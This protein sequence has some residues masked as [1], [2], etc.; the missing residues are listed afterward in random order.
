MESIKLNDILQLGEEQIENAKIRFMVP[1]DSINFDPNSDA[2]DVNKQDKIN[3]CDLV[4]NR[5]S[6]ISFKAGVIAIGF[7]RIRDDY[8]LM[9]GVVRVLHDNGLSREATAEYLT[10]KYNYRLVI[11]F[12]KGFQNGI[13]LAKNIIDE[14]EVIEIWNP[15]KS[16]A[17]TAFPGYKNIKIG[18]K[19]LK[20]KLDASDEWRT[21]LKSRKGVYV[22]SDKETGK[23][24]VGSAYGDDG[25]LGRWRTYVT[26]GY[27]KHEV[28][29]GKY[30]NKKLE[31]LVSEKGMAYIEKNFQYA[32]LETFTDDVSDEY[33][34][35]RESY[36]K[37]VLLTRG[38]FGYNVN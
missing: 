33:I 23:L 24:Y 36:W 27:D 3:L 14:L 16:L 28:E 38:D 6:S 22:I 8:W 5:D 25:I 35:D 30:P 10:K 29:N 17:E 37:E 11:K 9:T 18:F 12:H 4:Y 21:A 34:I 19:D 31:E 15:E 26:S 13:V 7:I 32:L 1:N 20:K 2:A